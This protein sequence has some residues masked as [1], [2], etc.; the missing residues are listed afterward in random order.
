MVLDIMEHLLVAAVVVALVLMEL[1]ER[2]MV[3]VEQEEMEQRLA[4]VVRP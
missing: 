2:P 3:P 1:L 4:L